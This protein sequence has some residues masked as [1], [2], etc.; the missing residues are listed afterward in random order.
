MS[1]DHTV[2]DQAVSAPVSVMSPTVSGV[3]ARSGNDC[4]TRCL[5][6][7]TNHAKNECV[8]LYSNVRRRQHGGKR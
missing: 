8:D 2:G 7:H 3:I 6:A 4:F 1:V 5:C